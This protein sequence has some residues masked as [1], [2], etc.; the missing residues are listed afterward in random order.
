ML[1]FRLQP[2]HIFSGRPFPDQSP[3]YYDNK[4]LKTSLCILSKATLSTSPTISLSLSI[5]LSGGKRQQLFG[6][7]LLFAVAGRSRIWIP[8]VVR[9]QMIITQNCE[10]KPNYLIK[11]CL[12]ITTANLYI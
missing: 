1:S 12:L 6:S 11:C 4:T 5:S 2:V 10:F 8:K 9:Q 7:Q 3:Y